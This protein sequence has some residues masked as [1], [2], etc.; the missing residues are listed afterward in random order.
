MESG[1][2]PLTTVHVMDSRCPVCT[3]DGT[4]N[5]SITG[6]SVIKGGEDKPKTYSELHLNFDKNR[7]YSE[8]E[9][10]WHLLEANIK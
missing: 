8:I 1:G 3:N 7:I 4:M 2:S 6:F 10:K 5:G 9:N